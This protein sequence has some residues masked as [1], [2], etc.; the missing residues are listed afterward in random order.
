MGM[1]CE[2]PTPLLDDI[3]CRVTEVVVPQFIGFGGK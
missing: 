3:H 1:S 2:R